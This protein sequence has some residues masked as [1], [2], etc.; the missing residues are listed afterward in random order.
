MSKGKIYYVV[1]I[2]IGFHLQKKAEVT[3]GSI[4]ALAV[5]H[6]LEVKNIHH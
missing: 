6:A 4:A 2:R 1:A 3:S 5:Q